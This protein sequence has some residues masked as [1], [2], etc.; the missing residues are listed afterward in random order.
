MYDEIVRLKAECAAL[1]TE[2]Q[3]LLSD[4]HISSRNR[5][6]LDREVLDLQARRDGI[7]LGDTLSDRRLSPSEQFYSMEF[8]GPGKLNRRIWVL[9]QRN[10][11]LARKPQE[12]K[13]A[14]MEALEAERAIASGLRDRIG[15]LEEKVRKGKQRVEN[16]ETAQHDTKQELETIRV[17]SDTDLG[18]LRSEWTDMK[19]FLAGEKQEV[20]RLKE[21]LSRITEEKQIVLVQLRSLQ[22]QKPT[23]ATR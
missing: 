8:D 19:A 14:H 7:G 21:D 9:E 18:R 2:R 6:E 23:T 5:A 16:A 11:D 1:K 3:A 10:L 17:K 13:K 12:M 4:C 20:I 15:K 22:Y